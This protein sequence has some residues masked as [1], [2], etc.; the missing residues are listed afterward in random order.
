[1]DTDKKKKKKRII[2]I[3]AFTTNPMRRKKKLIK[4]KLK[5]QHILIADERDFDVY[6]NTVHLEVHSLRRICRT[7][8]VHH[9]YILRKLDHTL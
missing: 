8:L 6:L 1:M 7:N 4:I 5:F 9:Q 3:K 2:K